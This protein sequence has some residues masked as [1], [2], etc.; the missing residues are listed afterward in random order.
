MMIGRIFFSVPSCVVVLVLSAC[1]SKPA[2][3]PADACLKI[4]FDDY[5]VVRSQHMIDGA[6]DR[7][8]IKLRAKQAW[9]NSASE[10]QIRNGNPT[11]VDA[12]LKSATEV[13]DDDSW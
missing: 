8:L 11:D 1:G 6:A 9:A 3:S 13:R 2:L 10:C 5:K 12:A 4:A 7:V